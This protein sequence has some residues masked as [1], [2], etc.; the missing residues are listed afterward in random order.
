MTSTSPRPLLWERLQSRCFPLLQTVAF[1]TKK[2]APINGAPFSLGLDLRPLSYNAATATTLGCSSTSRTVI[3][4][5]SH[6][7]CAIDTAA[8]RPS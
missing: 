3:A 6:N 2:G 8:S 7:N 4:G 5:E 1:I